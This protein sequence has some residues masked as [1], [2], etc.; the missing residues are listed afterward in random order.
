MTTNLVTGITTLAAKTMMATS[1]APWWAS[2]MT[3]PT[4]VL[5][6]ARPRVRVSSMGRTLAGR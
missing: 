5:P 6:W 4:M 2:S 3:P 1:Q